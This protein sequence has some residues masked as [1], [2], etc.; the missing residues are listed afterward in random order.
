MDTYAVVGSSPISGEFRRGHPS[1]EDAVEDAVHVALGLAT[2]LRPGQELSV[3]V[4]EAVGRDDTITHMS[5]RIGVNELDFGL[6]RGGV[7]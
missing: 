2:R 4:E 1:R 7:S 6:S 5:L 3:A